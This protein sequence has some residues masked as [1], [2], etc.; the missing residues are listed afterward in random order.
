MRSLKDLP[1]KIRACLLAIAAIAVPSS[2]I[3]QEQRCIAREDSQAVVAN[4]LP[5]LLNSAANKCGPQV[6]NSYLASNAGAL[7][8][9]LTPLSER[10]WPQARTTL[11]YVMNTEFPENAEILQFGRQALADG[12]TKDL[13]RS[14]CEAVDRLTEQ[15]APLPP[16]NFANIFALFL[17]MGLNGNKESDLKIC[18]APAY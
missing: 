2:A 13:D 8:Q 11:E 7:S 15:L 4:L 17:E 16:E 12:I 14:A 9:R 10:S 5:S 6:Q 3:A 18:S 1:M